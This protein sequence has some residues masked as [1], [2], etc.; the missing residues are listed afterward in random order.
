MK[1]HVSCNGLIGNVQVPDASENG[2]GEHVD[3][4]RCIDVKLAL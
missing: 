2:V 1:H 3:V 4:D